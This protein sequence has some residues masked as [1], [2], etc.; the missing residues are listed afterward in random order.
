[1]HHEQSPP[2]EGTGCFKPGY[3][4]PNHPAAAVQLIGSCSLTFYHNRATRAQLMILAMAHCH[5][6]VMNLIAARWGA[7]H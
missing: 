3:E 4:Q 5:R 6:R 1:M 2:M 7:T